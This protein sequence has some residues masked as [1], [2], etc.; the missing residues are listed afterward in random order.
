MKTEFGTALFE[1]VACM[2]YDLLDSKRQFLHYL[3][4]MKLIE[5]PGASGPPMP[6]ACKSD[7][8][9]AV[10]IDKAKTLFLLR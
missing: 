8:C 6:P 9:M 1:D 5:I 3:D 4:N 10:E 7:P 2:M